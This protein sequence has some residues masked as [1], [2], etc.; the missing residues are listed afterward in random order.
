MVPNPTV[1][2]QINT[3]KQ[4]VRLFEHGKWK[5]KRHWRTSGSTVSLLCDFL[6]HTSRGS[7]SRFLSDISFLAQAKWVLC[8]I[9]DELR[10]HLK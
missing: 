4:N 7:V 2:A 10:G 1:P 8:R 3:E 9:T 6:M 5:S